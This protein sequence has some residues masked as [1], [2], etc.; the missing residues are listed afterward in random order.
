MRG[1]D[2]FL[3]AVI[4]VLVVLLLRQSQ[5]QPRFTV[6]RGIVR[7]LTFVLFAEEPQSEPSVQGFGQNPD[8]IAGEL[9]APPVDNTGSE[10]LVSVNHGAG[11]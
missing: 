9:G 4:A 10:G 7:T 6:L 3:W 8:C 1:R 2:V 11:W 5:Y